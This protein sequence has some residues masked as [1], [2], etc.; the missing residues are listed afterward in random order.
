MALDVALSRWLVLLHR[1]PGAL[2]GLRQA[3]AGAGGRGKSTGERG[4]PSRECSADFLDQ[5]ISV[6]TASTVVAYSLYAFDPDVARKLGTE[7]LGLTCALRLCFGIFVALYLVHRRGQG[8]NP[9][10]SPPAGPPLLINL[11]L[12]AAAA[13]AVLYVWK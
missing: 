10:P 3:P 8:E 5:M 4:A 12:W 7:H 11:G 1:P 9:T 2:P 13:A 6:V